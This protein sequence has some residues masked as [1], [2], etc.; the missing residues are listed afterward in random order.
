MIEKRLIVEELRQ[1]FDVRELVSKE[2]Y[3]KNGENAWR[4]FDTDLLQ[5]LLT[6]RRE[7]VKAP[8]VCNNWAKG[9]QLSQRG[10]RENTAPMVKAKTEAGTLYLSAHTMGKAIDLSSPKYTADLLRKM[11]EEKADLLPCN[12]RME[13]GKSAPTWLHIDTATAPSQ[14]DKI[15]IFI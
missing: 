12:I 15:Y 13:S 3:Q 1:Y 6:I 5:V 10:L 11:I 4:Y 7:I 2:V 8:M 14:S 9:G